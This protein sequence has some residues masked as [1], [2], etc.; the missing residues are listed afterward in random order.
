MYFTDR[1]NFH[2]HVDPHIWTSIHPNFP[3]GVPVAIPGVL[4]DLNQD[5][6]KS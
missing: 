3:K 1:C 5:A 6:N 2:A 4:T